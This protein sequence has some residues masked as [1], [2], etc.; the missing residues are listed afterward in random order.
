MFI[1][2][3]ETIS[4][5][6]PGPNRP[7]Q[8]WTGKLRPLR[9]RAGAVQPV[10]L[11]LLERAAETAV[12]VLEK[13]SEDVAAGRTMPDG[14][15]G[16]TYSRVSK[17]LRLTLALHAKFE[18]DSLKSD[19]EKAARAAQNRDQKR[20]VE[21]AVEQAI[22]AAENDHRGKRD[23]GELYS[24]LYERLNDFKDHSDFGRKSTGEI[25]EQICRLLNITF[26]PALWQDEPWAIAEAK[27]KPPGSPF[28]DWPDTANDDDADDE[29]DEPRTAKGYAAALRGGRTLSTPSPT[30]PI[31]ES[32]S[33]AK[34]ER[35]SGTKSSKTACPSN[36]DR[37]TCRKPAS[38]GGPNR[39]KET[40][41]HFKYVVFTAPAAGQD[42][43][44][45]DWYDNHHLAE[46][47]EVDGFVAAQRF[48]IVETDHNSQPASRYM[49]IYEIEADD[50][51]TVLDRLV[52][53]GTGGGMVISDALDRASAKTIL[54]EPIGER[55]VKAA[56]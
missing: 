16:L 46:V 11:R 15:L 33:P 32:S 53:N 50:P 52:E 54:Y 23:Y 8:G 25:V 19:E 48:K 31:S 14:D 49:A 56:E 42:D 41:P 51:K 36:T 4:S 39:G 13:I 21:H 26:D 3:N 9:K 18:E 12:T 47:L 5:G 45:N 27:A 35:G 30:S 38:A 22:T 44:Y 7:Q 17:A 1:S 24:E 10:A 34:R 37:R 6:Q 55:L 20:T 29:D 43:A 2:M 40:M 28:A